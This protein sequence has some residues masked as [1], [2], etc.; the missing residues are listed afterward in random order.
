MTTARP[1]I[2]WAGG[3]TQLLSALERH[4]PPSFATYHEPFLGGGALFFHLRGQGRITRA[5][6]SDA[7][8]YLVEAYRGVCSDV[9]R[10]IA[11]LREY[12]EAHS[13]DYFMRVRRGPPHSFQDQTVETAAWFIY[14]NK[15]CYNGLWRTNRKGEYNAPPDRDKPASAILDADNLRACS[16]A[17]QGVELLHSDFTETQH[18]A[19]PGDFCYFDCPYWPLSTTASFTAYT[20]DPFGPTEQAALEVMARRL[21]DRGV[22]VLL[23]N[24]SAHQVRA[25]YHSWTLHEVDARRAV[26]CK[27]EKR[28]AVKELIIT[29]GCAA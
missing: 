29:P 14:I 6:L 18:R 19:L 13:Y 10:V 17:L 11:R 25:L 26:N 12:Q 7:N 3:K 5:V 27:A 15:T 2:R 8:P 24:S 21:S 16:E 28:G 1:L 9:E 20:K 22:H 4:V 23:S